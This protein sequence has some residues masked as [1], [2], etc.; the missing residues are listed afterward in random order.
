MSNNLPM[1]LLTS[2]FN[3][4]KYNKCFKGKVGYILLV[5]KI[6]KIAKD[7]NLTIEERIKKI[8][9]LV[10]PFGLT[11]ALTAAGGMVPG[12]PLLGSSIG[13]LIAGLLGISIT[14]L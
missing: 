10:A 4:G 11:I 3:W 12:V 8:G 7:E 9:K 2:S 14:E 13:N 5:T 6:A 1:N